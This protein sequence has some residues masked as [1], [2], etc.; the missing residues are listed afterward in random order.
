MAAGDERRDSI[1]ERRARRRAARRG[2]KRFEPDTSV[3]SPCISVCQVDNATGFCIGCHRNIDEIR[4][5]MIMSA[6]EKHQ[7]L[8]NIEDRKG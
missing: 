5:W 6:D 4:D 7:V 3:P 2:I 1:T 8:K